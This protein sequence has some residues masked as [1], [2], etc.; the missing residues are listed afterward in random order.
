M[1]DET[2]APTFDQVVLPYLPDAHRLARWLMRNEHDA[3]DVVQEATLRALRYFRTF[4]GGNRR[5]WFLSIVRNTC[6]GWR[7]DASG[8]VEVFDEERHTAARSIGDPERLALRTDNAR[9]IAQAMRNVPPRFRELLVR[10]ELQG[11]S[12]KELADVMGMPIGTVMS[13]LSRGREALRAA[14]Q[15]DGRTPRE[16]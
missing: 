5:A 9:T 15:Q 12:Y 14:L 6:L 16:A 3:Q 11:L 4:A 1:E 10:R 7:H 8:A 2:T 13:G